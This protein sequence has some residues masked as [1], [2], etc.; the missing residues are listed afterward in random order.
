MLPFDWSEAPATG[1]ADTVAINVTGIK[2]S[3]VL[4]GLIA[5]SAGADPAPV[6][7]TD[8]TV[9]DG[10]ITGATVSTANKHLW[11]IWAEARA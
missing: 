10:T 5:W 9:A 11:V 4:L 7:T 2:S 1:A 3:D 8:F 6:D